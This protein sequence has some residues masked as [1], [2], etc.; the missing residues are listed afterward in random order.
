MTNRRTFIKEVDIEMKVR[1][2]VVNSWGIRKLEKDMFN[3]VADMIELSAGADAT[4]E[5]IKKLKKVAT[6]FYGE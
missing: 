3:L 2:E 1:G 4:A 5:T 6:S